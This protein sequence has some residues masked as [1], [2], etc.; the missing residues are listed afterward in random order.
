MPIPIN[1]NDLINGTTVEWERIEFKEGWNDLDII[2]T[3]CAFAND[4]GNLGGGYVII[5]IAEKGGKPILPPKGLQPEQ[6]NKIQSELLNICKQR[7]KPDYTPIVEP[8][9]FQKN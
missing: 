9:T 8:V 7:L 2:H 5:G 3:I 4:F 1:I 6:V